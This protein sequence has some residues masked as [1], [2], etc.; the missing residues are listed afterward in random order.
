[1]K[2]KLSP[3]AA[4]AFL[5]VVVVT[6]TLAAGDAKPTVVWPAGD[7]KWADSATIKGASMAVL[8]GD[9]KTGAYG[10]LKKLSAGASL[11]MHWHT[12]ESKVVVV[13]GT[14]TFTPEGGAAKDMGPGSFTWIPGG[15]KHAAAC[16][17]GADCLYFEEQAGANDYKT[18]EKK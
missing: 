13:S 6:G 12:A 17:A 16:K 1:M 4:L 2:L 11:P 18:D 9:P 10:S 3:A 15:N 14:I 5:A 8:W 7:I